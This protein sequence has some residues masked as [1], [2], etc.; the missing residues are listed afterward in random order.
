M[1]R[2]HRK[3]EEVGGVA[4]SALV[5]TL[6]NGHDPSKCMVGMWLEPDGRVVLHLDCVA[7]TSAV[8]HALWRR[9][10][11]HS[12]VHPEYGILIWV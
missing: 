1:A 12:D 4:S 5:G 6:K 9:F 8:A 7:S 2:I 3:A 10:E 11:V